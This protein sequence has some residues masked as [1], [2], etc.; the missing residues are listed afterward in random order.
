VG[1][2][3]A[4][5]AD[6]VEGASGPI[7]E[8]DHRATITL[9]PG[10]AEWLVRRTLG[11]RGGARNQA[12]VSF[13][14]PEPTSALVGLS[15][16]GAKEHQR[17]QLMSTT[18]AA[19]Q[20]R[21]G[22]GA[23]TAA[24]LLELEPESTRDARLWVALAANRRQTVEYR[25]LVEMPFSDG[26]YH[27]TIAPVTGAGRPPSLVVEAEGGTLLVAGKRGRGGPVRYRPNKGIE[28]ALVPTTSSIDGA[29]A[30]VPVGDQYF[31][32][33]RV[34]APARFTAVPEGAYVVLAL[35]ASR[36][37]TAAGSKAMV[38]AAR[39]YLSHLP[40]AHVEVITFHR[41]AT[42]RYGEFV[43]RK[44]AQA[45]LAHLE[46]SRENGSEV[47]QALHLAAQRLAEAP[48]GA[49]KRLVL[50]TD[51]MVRSGLGADD[52]DAAVAPGLALT[53]IALFGP[54]GS[55][56]EPLTGHP[57]YSAAAKTG[58]ELWSGDPLHFDDARREM[59]RL[60]R[61]TRVDDIVASTAGWV[62]ASPPAPFNLAEGEGFAGF[63]LLQ[64]PLPWLSLS[65][66]LWQRPVTAS[67]VVSADETRVWTSLAASGLLADLDRGVL[68][69]LAHRGG[70]VTELT[71]YNTP[72]LA[73]PPPALTVSDTNRPRDP[74]LAVCSVSVTG[75]H[76][77][78]RRRWLAD[79]L[80]RPW[81]DCGGA[82]HSATV[83][84]T[85][86]GA[87]VVDVGKV[88]LSQAAPPA[89]ADCLR[90][91]AWALELGEMF[92]RDE[93]KTYTVRVRS[94]FH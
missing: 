42:P 3:A 23:A 87:E 81:F 86:T 2:S 4:A 22:G 91:A 90:R 94:M 82:L 15:L 71:S 26:A 10:H 68:R 19:E 28:L 88:K 78:N 63:E 58:G 89:M 37:I 49:D 40:D 74:R 77:G 66:R 70:T 9:R 11:S 57:W 80:L 48:P 17:A 5:R 59:L 67:L 51:G 75:R 52:I 44:S 73:E 13:R 16:I 79:Q 29:V 62:S 53:H 54:H 21:G 72:A 7:V 76:P 61:A 25:M 32:R 46:L 60:A 1:A 64:E 93:P 31:T 8:H 85:T 34:S 30:V 33:A 69:E 56:V 43:A 65:G 84:L 38:G 45:D 41:A 35:D 47:V 83:T 20:Y 14:L 24:A 92:E 39:A 6:T 12:L 50:F 55:A 27:L 18:A 36:S